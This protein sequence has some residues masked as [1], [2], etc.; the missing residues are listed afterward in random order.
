VNR[1]AGR[2]E[3]PISEAE[4]VQVAEKGM[5]RVERLIARFIELS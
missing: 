4:I 1:A 2:G 3:G 5:H